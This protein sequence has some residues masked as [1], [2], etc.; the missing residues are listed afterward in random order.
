[1]PMSKPSHPGMIF[2]ADIM[3]RNRQ[4]ILVCRDIF[5]SYTTATMTPSESANDIKEA[6]IQSISNIRSQLPVTIRTD[7]ASA[8]KALVNDQ[9]LKSMEIEIQLTDPSNKNSV[10]CQIEDDI[11][12]EDLE[13]DHSH[14][15]LEDIFTQ[16]QLS[17]MS[18]VQ[19]VDDLYNDVLDRASSI[20]T[21][22]VQRLDDILPIPRHSSA[23]KKVIS[24]A[25]KKKRISPP[26]RD[27]P[28]ETL[29]KKLR[30]RSISYQVE[31]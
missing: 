21:N 20:N 26:R 4:K 24:K 27:L 8:F 15:D 17:P 1:M 10:P 28:Y 22:E 3:V 6:L 23:K 7:S 16:A 14:D 29:D 31:K 18:K 12:I 30:N 5:S 11:Q 9:Q 13:W 25:I 2:N 19:S